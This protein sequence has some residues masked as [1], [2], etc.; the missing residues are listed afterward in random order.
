M[1]SE[2]RTVQGSG[3]R[4]QGSGFRV[5]GSPKTCLPSGGRITVV[6]A[7]PRAVVFGSLLFAWQRKHFGTGTCLHYSC[8]G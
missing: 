8:A 4:V 3:F 1:G 7:R 2:E 6:Q 5:Q